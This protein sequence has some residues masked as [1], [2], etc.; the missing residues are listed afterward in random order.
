MSDKPIRVLVAEDD[1]AVRGALT[2]LI[3]DEP[4]LELV[5]AVGD[6]DQAIAAAERERPDVALLDVRM[7]GGGGA[8][9]ARGIKRACPET[10]ILALSAYEDRDT[11][12]E[13]VEAGVAGYLVKGSTIEK[14]VSSIER[15]A[16]GQGS[17]SVEVTGDVIEEL[18]GQLAVQRRTDERRSRSQ[19][20]IRQALDDPAALQLV[21]QPIC[22][23]DG[24]LVGS[25]ALSRFRGPPKRGP[26]AWF[27]EASDVGLRTELE[28]VAIR[29]AFAAVPSLP[30][31]T[32]LAV[33]VSPATVIA[34]SFQKLIP[35]THGRRIVVEV[36]EHAPIADYER[37]NEAV[38]RL[39]AEGVRLAIDDAGAGFASLRHILR[40]DPDF[41]KLDGTLIRGIAK[42]RSKQALA[43]GLISFAEKIGATIVAE[44]IETAGE[45]NALAALGVQYGQGFY[46]ARPVPLAKLGSVQPKRT[47][48]LA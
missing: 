29:A 40:L 41:I 21:F 19:K 14:I 45:L 30:S 39:K 43:A 4:R 31:N 32:C 25:E 24:T 1:V 9:A 6:A 36:T 48:M 22:K 35:K 23:L 47:K 11:V 2:A 34:P 16:N 18:A 42:D 44:G 37:M 3:G 26:E 12:L 13:M 28:L 8:R 7:P 33:N 27:A 10:R 5:A 17:L 38:Q 46:L 15:A 20:R